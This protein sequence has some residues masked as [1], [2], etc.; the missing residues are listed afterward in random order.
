[1]ILKGQRNPNNFHKSHIPIMSSFAWH[2]KKVK[3]KK[4]DW[5]VNFFQDLS[6]EIVES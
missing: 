4:N 3:T 6:W 5:F 1:M 2:W